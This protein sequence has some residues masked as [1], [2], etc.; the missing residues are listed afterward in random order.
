M[1]LGWVER[2]GKTHHNSVHRI[3]DAISPWALNSGWA[4]AMGFAKTLNP[5]LIQAVLKQF[6]FGNATGGRNLHN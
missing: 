6:L 3:G 1:G 4:K 2:L 5:C